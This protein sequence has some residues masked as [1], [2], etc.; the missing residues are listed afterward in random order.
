MFIVLLKGESSVRFWGVLL[1]KK[2][3]AL[4]ISNV[5]EIITVTLVCRLIY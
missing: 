2:N 1:M 5:I 3:N 4:S